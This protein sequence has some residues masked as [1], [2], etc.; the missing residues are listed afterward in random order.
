MVGIN[1][2]QEFRERLRD[3]MRKRLREK[4]V[5][6][7]KEIEFDKKRKDQ[8]ALDLSLDFR[9]LDIKI[10]KT[11]KDIEAL[12]KD[13]DLNSLDDAIKNIE[14]LR[15][16]FGLDPLDLFYIHHVV[17]DIEALCKDL[18]IPIVSSVEELN[19]NSTVIFASNHKDFI[20]PQE[21]NKILLQKLS[22]KKTI[23]GAEFSSNLKGL[24]NDPTRNLIDFYELIVPYKDFKETIL[25]LLRVFNNIQQTYPIN[26]FEIEP[27]D[28]RY[29][30]ILF[31]RPDDK[32][33]DKKRAAKIVENILD[34]LK[35]Y[36][37]NLVVY[38]GTSH[39]EDLLT[40]LKEIIESGNKEGIKID[41]MAVYLTTLDRVICDFIDKVTSKKN[42]F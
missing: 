8:V 38:T 17:K 15:K 36:G 11:V 31:R 27:F 18:G 35:T 20:E 19:P 24:L 12:R 14:P 13:L 33:F 37:D 2:E 26:G 9:V 10:N 30:E 21:L 40:K 41:N 32:E 22:N 28:L 3:E 34:L 1:K 4:I 39:A 25:G 23:L 6:A 5:D 7:G 16:D 29:A 42:K